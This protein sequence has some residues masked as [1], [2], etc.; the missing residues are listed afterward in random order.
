MNNTDRESIAVLAS[1][2][3]DLR[4]DVR[5]LREEVKELR[6]RADKWKGAFG[7]LMLAGGAF[8]SVLTWVAQ[9]LKH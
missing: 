7:L 6:S 4:E 1:K 2:V 8:G 3:D 5:G 9:M